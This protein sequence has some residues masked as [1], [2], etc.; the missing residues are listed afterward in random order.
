[1]R[2]VL[3]LNKNWSYLPIKSEPIPAKNSVAGMYI[4]AKTERL[5]WGCGTLQHVDTPH[6]WDFNAEINPEPWTH[7]DLPHDYIITQVP[8]ESEGNPRG[9]FRYHKAWYRRHV[10]I[11]ASDCGRRI[12]V[13]FEGVTGACEVYFNGC[14]M[15]HHASGYVPFEIDVT[16]YVRYDSDNVIAVKVDPEIFDCWWYAGGGIYRNVW[17]IKTAPVAVDLYGVFAPASK[18]GDGWR[19]DVETTL[20]SIAYAPSTVKIL[21]QLLAPTGEIVADAA[22]ETESS[23]RT[24]ATSSCVLKVEDPLL[25]D[26][27]SPVLYT[28]RT[29]VFDG[30]DA[31]D[32]VDTT[33]GFRT[34]LLSPTQGCLLNGRPIKLKGVCDHHSFGALGKAVPDNICRYKVKQIKSMGANALRCAHYPH[35]EATMDELDRQG[36]LVM[37]ET[38]RFESCDESIEALEMLVKRDRNHPSVFIWSLG[39]EEMGYQHTEQGRNIYRA[40]AHAAKRLDPTRPTTLPMGMPGEAIN[41]D[42]F[43]VISV[44]YSLKLLQGIHERY[45]DKPFISSENCAVG[46][47]RGQHYGDDAEHGRLDARDRERNVDTWYFGREGTWKYIMSKE[48]NCGAFQWNAFDYRGEAEWPRLCSAS[49]AFDMFGQKKDAFYQNLSHW[50][51]V[52]MIHILPHWNHRGLEGKN[53][54]VWCYTNC[55]EC[56]LLLNGKSLGRVPV[57]KYTHVEWV[58]PYQQGRIEAVGYANGEA[59]V[60]D[61]QETTGR[62]VALRL[63]AENAPVYATGDD[64]ALI[65]C[66][67]VDDQGR[68]VPDATG[69][70]RF[71]CTGGT[72][73]GTGSDESDHMPVNSP[74]RMMYAGLASAFVKVGDVVGEF[75]LIARAEGMDS[76]C[77]TVQVEDAEKSVDRSEASNIRRAIVMTAN[78][79]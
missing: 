16:D 35:N 25:W 66:Y 72:I 27:D 23:A 59:V 20:R 57:E 31:V 6:Q 39:N 65:T 24:V 18:D 8:Q 68:E 34:V 55:E 5:K 22:Y 52:P 10:T 56:E 61:V 60:Q 75:T 17:L 19:V 46:S 36:L 70:I 63:R 42:V 7:I 78:E 47:S 79:E 28:L 2:E 1:M 13:Y 77:I 33:I 38:R 14:F 45:P 40:M 41:C 43:D 3:S 30:E 32:A 53:I 69:M 54:T 29:T 62:A 4:P 76:A 71:S 12:T 73:V 50:T 15:K 21:Q 37:A 64:I 58:V 49:G 9:F 26:V 44:N 51:D 11:P 48:W 74:D 67:A